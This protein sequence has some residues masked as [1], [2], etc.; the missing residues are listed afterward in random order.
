MKKKSR[1]PQPR[2]LS[3]S[4]N[5]AM[6]A[7]LADLV[8]I[9][10]IGCVVKARRTILPSPLSEDSPIKRGTLGEIVGTQDGLLIVDFDVGQ[11]G[12]Q[13]ICDPD[14]VTVTSIPL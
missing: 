2:R 12:Q 10:P 4:Q 14:E 6:A 1:G 9:T 7:L 13:E 11:W 5:Q 3:K 8:P